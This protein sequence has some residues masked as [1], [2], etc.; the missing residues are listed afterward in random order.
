MAKRGSPQYPFFSEASGTT[1]EWQ[2]VFGTMFKV[3][4]LALSGVLREEYSSVDALC[5]SLEKFSFF[6]MCRKNSLSVHT[7]APHTRT[8]LD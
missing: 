5:K 6:A 1:G 8:V 2:G 3:W 7:N 4:C